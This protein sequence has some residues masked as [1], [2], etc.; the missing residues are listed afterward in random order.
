MV[1]GD[2]EECSELLTDGLVLLESIKFGWKYSDNSSGVGKKVILTL[3]TL[4]K[5][6]KSYNSL[7]DGNFS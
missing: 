5:K 4:K 2:R 6:K 7:W 1:R 3:L